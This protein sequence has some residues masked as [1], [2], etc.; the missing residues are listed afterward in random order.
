MVQRDS[1]MDNNVTQAGLNVRLMALESKQT[2]L[3]KKNQKMCKN[4]A[5]KEQ[6]I[7]DLEKEIDETQDSY[8]KARSEYH[9][10][11]QTHTMLQ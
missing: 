5:E 1:E 9:A 8:E 10:V 11:L 6:K 2:N 4:L 7:K 3:V